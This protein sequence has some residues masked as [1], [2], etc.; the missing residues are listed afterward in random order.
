MDSL[1]IRTGLSGSVNFKS[2]NGDLQSL[3]LESLCVVNY[4][5]LEEGLLEKLLYLKVI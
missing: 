5:T 2:E 4:L 3:V 1:I